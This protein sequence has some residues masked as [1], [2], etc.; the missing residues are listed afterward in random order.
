MSILFGQMESQE[1]T[2][3]Q[4]KM[5]IARN[6]SIHKNSINELQSPSKNRETSI[7][8]QPS[9]PLTISEIRAIFHS[10]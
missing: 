10:K 7:L 6:F 2:L 4:S 8:S 9:K 1:I 3:L 5:P